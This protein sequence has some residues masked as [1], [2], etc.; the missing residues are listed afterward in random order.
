MKPGEES[1]RFEILV[2]RGSEASQFDA[3]FFRFLEC[4]ALGD[5]DGPMTIQSLPEGDFERKTVVLWNGA[6]AAEFAR[7]WRG[8]DPSHSAAAVASA[9]ALP[10]G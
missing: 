5:E 3:A 9:S 6:A 8:C 4:S 7:L 10:V 1:N 2:G